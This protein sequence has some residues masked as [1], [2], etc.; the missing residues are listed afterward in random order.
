MESKWEGDYSG[1]VSYECE[2][3]IPSVPVMPVVYIDSHVTYGPYGNVGM[4]S[5]SNV[6]LPF[7]LGIIGLFIYSVLLF[8][9]GGYLIKYIIENREE[10][11][12]EDK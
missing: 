12:K 2:Y 9:S 7:S 8:S 10:E 4:F 5:F 3:V 6:T 11:E 1:T